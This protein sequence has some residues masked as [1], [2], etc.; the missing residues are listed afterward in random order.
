MVPKS[1]C[2][3]V[4]LEEYG[5]VLGFPPHL[6]TMLSMAVQLQNVVS[7]SNVNPHQEN[8][9]GMMLATSAHLLI[10]LLLGLNFCSLLF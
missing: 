6:F 7:K 8:G 1:A 2:V 9:V 3:L 10:K 4:A 5:W